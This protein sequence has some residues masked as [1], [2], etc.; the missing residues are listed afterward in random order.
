MMKKRKLDE[1]QRKSNLLSQY[2][3]PC[4]NCGRKQ[5]IYYTK[6]STVCDYCGHL[7]FRTR[8]EFDRYYFKQKLRRV[9]RNNERK[10]STY[11]VNYN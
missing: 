2:K 5:I 4:Y 3:C 1:F 9:M 11:R 8:A 10:E 6:E 7:I